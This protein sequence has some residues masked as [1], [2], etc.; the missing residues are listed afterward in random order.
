[1]SNSET[2]QDFCQAWRSRFPHSDLPAAWEEYVRANL[3][4]DQTRVDSLREEMEKEE[5]YVQW[6]RVRLVRLVWITR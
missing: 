2:F 6:L 3:A 1:M 5:M 4:K